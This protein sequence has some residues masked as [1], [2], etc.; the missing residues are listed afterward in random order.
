LI[1]YDRHDGLA[2]L[3]RRNLLTRRRMAQLS[4]RRIDGQHHQRRHRSKHYLGVA[5]PAPRRRG[6]R[7]LTWHSIPR[8][9]ALPGRASIKLDRD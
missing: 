1:D 6:G 3:A 4:C 2:D 9:K 5:I 7:A 8:S